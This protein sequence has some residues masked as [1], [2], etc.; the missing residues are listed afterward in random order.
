MQEFI[1]QIK[2]LQHDLEDASYERDLIFQRALEQGTQMADVMARRKAK[3]KA[4]ESMFSAKDDGKDT[5]GEVAKKLEPGLFS[6]ITEAFAEYGRSILAPQPRK[7]GAEKSDYMKN[8][9]E[10]V[11]LEKMEKQKKGG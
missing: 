11:E 9:L 2:D 3:K 1:D 8:L 5:I 10:K 7:R 6:G 4:A